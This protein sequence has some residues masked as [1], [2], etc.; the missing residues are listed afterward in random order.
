MKYSLLDVFLPIESFLN[1]IQEISGGRLGVR[2]LNDSANRLIS[3]AEKTLKD[4]RWIDVASVRAGFHL[5]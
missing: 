3:S 1:N 2:T 5:I 4:D